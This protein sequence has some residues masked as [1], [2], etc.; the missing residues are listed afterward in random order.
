MYV[1]ACGMKVKN[2]GRMRFAKYS[3]KLIK[4]VL[5]HQKKEKERKRG[6]KYSRGAV[7]MESH[8]RSDR[9]FTAWREEEPCFA[10]KF[11]GFTCS[12]C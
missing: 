2:F 9:R 11:P 7:T 10:R 6:M 1:A 12:P 3:C 4:L 8:G 5:T